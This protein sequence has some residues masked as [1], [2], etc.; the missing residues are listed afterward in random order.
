MSKVAYIS[1]VRVEPVEG[2]IRRAHSPSSRSRCSLAYTARPPRTTAFPKNRWNPMTQ[3]SITRWPQPVA[4]CW[5]PLRARWQRV[6][7][8]SIK[9]AYTPR[10]WGR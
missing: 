8:P 1:R 6:E 10:R 3:P 2:K 9:I 4:D 7:C 5:A